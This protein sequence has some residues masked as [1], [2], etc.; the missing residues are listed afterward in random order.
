MSLKAKYIL[1]ILFGGVVLTAIIIRICINQTTFVDDSYIFLRLAE[2]AV[3]GHGFRWNIN[4]APLEG[5]T[6]FLYFL[7]NIFAVRFFLH[8]EL[9][10]QIFGIMTSFATI[11]FIY[12]LYNEV[13]PKL[14]TENLITT[15]LVSISPCFVYWSVAGMETSFYMMFLMFSLF[16]Y[17]KKSNAP[18]IYIVTGA[19][20]AILYLIRPECIVFFIYVLFFTSYQ[21]FRERN[22][23]KWLL[24]ICMVFGFQFI[25]A[26]YFMWHLKYFGVLFP[27]SYYAKVG[28]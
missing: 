9:F 13:D 7:I 10:L 25:F 12:L 28:G 4:E 26:S 15:I 20:F 11:V 27:N 1:A 23:S 2:N 3:N 5:Y 22:K 19:L 24:L 18:L 21:L 16:I 17:F 14:K 8:P 6:S